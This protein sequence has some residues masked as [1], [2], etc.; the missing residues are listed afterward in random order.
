MTPKHI[1]LIAALSLSSLACAHAD[2][3]DELGAEPR[4]VEQQPASVPSPIESIYLLEQLGPDQYAV[5]LSGGAT[6]LKSGAAT[7]GLPEPAKKA[8]IRTVTGRVLDEQGRPVVGAVIIAGTHLTAMLSTSMSAQHGTTTDADG[9]FSLPLVTDE[10]VRLLA[11][12]NDNAWSP[13]LE[14]E[15][16]DEDLE[17][18]VELAAPA[19]LTGRMERSGEAVPPIALITD[20]KAKPSF[21]VRVQG[22]PDGTYESP[23]LPPG[24]YEVGFAVDNGKLLTGG[25][26]DKRQVTLDAGEV[27]IADVSFVA[28]TALTLGYDGLADEGLRTVTYTILEGRHEPADAEALTALRKGDATVLARILV[29]GIDLRPPR[30]FHDIPAG[31]VTVCLEAH[32]A[33]ESGRAKHLL[34]F[35]CH[36]IELADSEDA[37][38]FEL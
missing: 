35:Q 36:T 19:Q 21:M 10:P 23:P 30:V 22:E 7:F 15:G 34:A 38:H 18:D 11:L 17:L 32:G 33:D 5:D 16:G 3:T 27:E 12:A 25:F 6:E 13:L 8:A 20:G 31:T 28:G 1:A 14:I 24:R 29:G 4:A 37:L 26:V 9:T 2:G